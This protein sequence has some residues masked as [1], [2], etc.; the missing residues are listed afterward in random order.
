MQPN[1]N[2]E[3]ENLKVP[4]KRV[5]NLDQQPVPNF[6]SREAAAEKV[7]PIDQKNTADQIKRELEM[8]E[9]DEKL[10]VEAK[11]KAQK[12][13]FLGEQEKIEH[14][15][16]VAREKGILFAVQTAKETNDPYLL[17]MLHDIL[18]KEGFY[19]SLGKN[20]SDDDDNNKK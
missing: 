4:E 1:F 9:L 12:I 15:L 16:T 2:N 18:A 6:E 10:K 7:N 13:E 19:K 17:D 11:N 8:M 3:T 14:L 5:E 20:V